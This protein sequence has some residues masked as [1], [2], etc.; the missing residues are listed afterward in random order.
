MAV[1]DVEVG[2]ILVESI[3]EDINDVRVV[4]S[5]GTVVDVLGIFTV[6]SVA[7]SNMELLYTTVG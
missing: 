5:F 3:L 1:A 4:V 2:A 6:L 7:E